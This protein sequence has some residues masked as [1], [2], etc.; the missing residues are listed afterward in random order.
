MA[1]KQMKRS[2]TSLIVGQMQFKAKIKYHF[3]PVRMIIFKS[4]QIV[5]AAE[6][7]DKREPSHNVGRNVNW[8]IHYGEQYAG[9]LKLKRE[10]KKL[11]RELP[12]DP[13]IPFL[14]IYLEN[15]HN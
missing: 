7:V 11:K 2:S 3:T 8:Y 14:Y 10:K 15:K 1:K 12:Y 6:Y 5:N 4:P 13:G 9:F